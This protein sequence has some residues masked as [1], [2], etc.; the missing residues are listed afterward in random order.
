M[1]I[2][3]VIDFDSTFIQVEALDTLAEIV[4]D[5]KG[6]KKQLIE[7]IRKITASGMEGKIPFEES[8]TQRLTLINIQKKDL[9]KLVKK[10]KKKISPS[11]VR[12]K[13]FFKKYSDRIY[14][15]SGGFKEYIVPLFKPYGIKAH[16]ILA[17]S[18]IFDSKGKVRGFDKNNMLAKQA[19]KVKQIKALNLKG[20]VYVIGDGYTDYEIKKA[21]L[22]EKFFVFCENI[23][24]ESVTEKGDYLLPNFDEFLYIMDLPRAYSYP[25]HRMKV[26]LLENIHPI[27]TKVF[28]SEAYEVL[29]IKEALNEEALADKIKDISILGIRSRTKITGKVLENAKRLLAIGAFCIGTNQLNLEACSRQGVAVFNAPYSNTRSVVELVIGEL[30][31][32]FRKTFDKSKHLHDGIWD[33]SAVGSHEIRGKKLGII[34]YG[35]IG[36]QL[37]VLAENLGMEVYFYDILDKLALG[38]SHKCS[39]LKE[40]LKTVDVVTVHVDGRASNENLISDREF[41]CMREGA[42]FLNLSRGFVVDIKALVK[43][44]KSGKIKGAAI[45]VFPNEPKTNDEQFTSVLQNL[46]NVILTPHVGGSTIEAQENI[47]KYVSHKIINFINSGDTTLSVNIPNLQLPSLK[48]AHRLIHIHQN[49]PGVLAK[50]NG[51]LAKNKINIEGQYLKTQENLGY[52]ITDVNKFYDREILQQLKNMTETIKFRVLY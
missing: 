34:G 5:Q 31:M 6:N 35:N 27:A 21:G 1:D 38:N 15:I 25:K 8:L 18:F 46:P 22:A 29:S 10:L 32:L 9:D 36:S 52:V 12:N 41:S 11:I 44:I 42:I 20:R 24:R 37:S 2:Y 26:L 16:H 43:Y 4:L 33:K 47:G 45:D 50:I 7:K 19:G 30:I 40:L 48:N 14:I 13:E 39:S 49:T 23:K 51:I 3:F 28:T 17:N